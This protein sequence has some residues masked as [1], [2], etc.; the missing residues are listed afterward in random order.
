MKKRIFSLLLA[1]W[2]VLNLA[3][4][5]AA[6]EVPEERKG[7][8]SIEVAVRYRGEPITDG[9]LTAVRIGYI[10]EDDGNYFF[11]HVVTREE[12]QLPGNRRSDAFR[13]YKAESLCEVFR[14]HG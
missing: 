14:N 2:V 7:S 4:T 8:C 13:L 12:I 11:S 1:V 5:A 10:D 3:V 6:K 9:K